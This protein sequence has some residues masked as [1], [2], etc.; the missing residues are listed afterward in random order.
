MSTIFK[1]L[2][3]VRGFIGLNLIEDISVDGM[4]HGSPAHH[5]RKPT[6]Q[7]AKPA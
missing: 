1:F 3:T 2:A 5:P 6:R 4:L 7:A